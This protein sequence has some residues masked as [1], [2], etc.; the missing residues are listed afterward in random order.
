LL[1][2]KFRGLFFLTVAFPARKKALIIN[3][4]LALCALCQFNSIERGA[5]KFIIRTCILSQFTSPSQREK[6][7]STAPRSITQL[8]YGF[9]GSAIWHLL[10]PAFISTACE[11]N[12]IPH[13]IAAKLK[14]FSRAHRLQMKAGWNRFDDVSTVYKYGLCCSSVYIYI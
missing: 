7:K 12:R 3:L 8:V 10:V 13:T 11:L 9:S 2:D 5:V 14:I 1:A 6:L 4:L